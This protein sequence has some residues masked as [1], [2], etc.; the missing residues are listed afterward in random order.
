MTWPLKIASYC[1]VYN[2]AA[3]C[4][5]KWQDMKLHNTP[6]IFKLQAL[7][8]IGWHVL[9]FLKFLFQVVVIV[10]VVCIPLRLLITNCYNQLNKYYDS[11]VVLYRI[12][13]EEFGLSLG[14]RQRWYCISHSFQKKCG[15]LTTPTELTISDKL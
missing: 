11:P 1:P 3:F 7:P 6:I 13:M 10:V 5:Y 9:G 4:I 2:K 15:V 12:I 14:K 8:A